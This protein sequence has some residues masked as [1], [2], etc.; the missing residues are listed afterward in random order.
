MIRFTLPMRLLLA[1]LPAAGLMLGGMILVTVHL[2]QQVVERFI[3]DY[4]RDTAQREAQAISAGIRGEITIAEGAARMVSALAATREREGQAP[5]LADRRQITEYLRQA[6]ALH[7]E[8]VGVWF[9]AEPDA[10]GPDNAARDTKD[11][12]VGMAGTGRYALYATS[13]EGTVLLQSPPDDFTTQDYYARAARS[14]RL[15]I[16]PPYIFPIQG[17]PTVLVS[18]AM[19]AMVGDRLIGVAGIDLDQRDRAQVYEGRHPFGAPIAIINTA[20]VWGYHPDP[21]R[22]GSAATFGDGPDYQFSIGERVFID[23]AQPYSLERT[24]SDGSRLRRFTWPVDLIPG[25]GRRLLVMDV[26]IDRLARPFAGIRTAILMAGV[27]CALL[28]TGLM[29]LAVRLIVAKPLHRLQGGVE[30]LNQGDYGQSLPDQDCPDVIGDLARG[31]EDFRLTLVERDRLR[32]DLQRMAACIAVAHD[33]IFMMNR[34]YSV[35]Y[36]NGQALGLLGV[37]EADTLLGRRISQFVTPETA[38]ALAGLRHQISDSLAR[39]GMWTG[40]VDNWTTLSGHRVEAVEFTASNDPG[41]DILVVARDVSERD[42]AERERQVLQRQI[43][44]QDKLETVGRL[45]GGVAHDFNNLLGAMLGYAEFLVADLP[46][47]SPARSYAE[48]IVAV[49]ARAKDLVRQI[50]G[51]ARTDAGV[52]EVVAARAIVEDAQVVLRSTVPATTRLTCMTEEG[53]PPLRV[54]QTQMMQVLMNLVINA[55]D[56]RREDTGDISIRLN[57]GPLPFTFPADWTVQEILPTA[58]GPH[59]VLEVTDQ[60]TGL[61]PDHLARMFEPFFTTKGQDKGT[62]LGL[63]NVSSIIKAH[64]G[65]LAVASRLDTGTVIRI[66]LPCLSGLGSN[67]RE[68]TVGDDGARHPGEGAPATAAVKPRGLKVLVVDDTDAM[69][70]L[71]QEGLSRRGHSVTVCN[72]P[73][74]ALALLVD[75]SQGYHALVT[76]QTMPGM[77]GLSLIHAAKGPNPGLICVLCT[78]HSAEVDEATARAGGADAF[79]LKPLSVKT[80]LD[81]LDALHSARV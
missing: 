38:A 66:T 23:Q 37:M 11:M 21:S 9:Y 40:V 47:E 33:A 53:L 16:L 8:A 31:L 58:D 50:L 26:P 56:A 28:L 80:L 69:G 75:K 61:S 15:T 64:G 60:G 70:E 62:G 4:G 41:G 6:A 3:N 36:A 22:L 79:F 52:Q 13:Q 73:Q 55:H 45:A 34:E 51:F 81:R 1:I 2:S 25:E 19:P 35:L 39:R 27:L 7:P 67:A 46:A 17:S 48:R 65:G 74:E 57:R 5:T 29:I 20:G 44:Q 32:L 42:R 49:G 59:V 68:P 10:L 18:H 43:L 72:N 54:N 78:G 14:H 77:T 24:R 71:L 30:R 76:D 12:Q 63:A